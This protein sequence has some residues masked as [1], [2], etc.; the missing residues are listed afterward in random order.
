MRKRGVS[1]LPVI[2]LSLFAGAV[3]TTTM[4]DWGWVSI[5]TV[6]DGNLI[7]MAFPVPFTLVRGALL[8]T[9]DIDIDAELPAEVQAQ[10]EVAIKTLEALAECPDCTLVS[11]ES[12]DAKVLI[13]KEG[14]RLIWN[15]DAEDALVRGSMPITPLVKTLKRWDWKKMDGVT[16]GRL[17]G[18]M[19][20]TSVQVDADDTKV[21]VR[22]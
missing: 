9:P 13:Q 3:M 18:A 19:H 1:T 8:F 21:R 15:V 22:L 10:K 11:V 6:D 12:P 7:K 2:A 4:L 16:A 20:G 17:L 5:Q 14:N